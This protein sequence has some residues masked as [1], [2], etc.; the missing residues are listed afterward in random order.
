MS[1][2]CIKWKT[3]SLNQI[4][5]RW[6]LS[7]ISSWSFEFHLF[8][9]TTPPPRR[10]QHV[11]SISKASLC[12]LNI[13]IPSQSV[14]PTSH[15]TFNIYMPGPFCLTTRLTLL[16][17]PMCIG[18]KETADGSI[19]CVCCVNLCVT[20]SSGTAGRGCD[21]NSHSLNLLKQKKYQNV[22]NK[23]SRNS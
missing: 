7:S 5:P 4:R 3:P 13:R 17:V 2:Y 21:K 16:S 11:L 22:A 6:S 23:G 20:N 9:T 8:A 10:Q 15:D 19:F 12:Q 1:L 18:V 14:F